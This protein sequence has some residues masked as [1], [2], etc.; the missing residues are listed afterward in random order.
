MA[1]H[2]MAEHD[3]A[4]H[5]MA[6]TKL[7]IAVQAERLHIHAT[8]PATCNCV[9]C[10]VVFVLLYFIHCTVHKINI[11]IAYK[12]AT[13]YFILV[14]QAKL[15]FLLHDATHNI[16]IHRWHALCAA[17]LCAQDV[18]SLLVSFCSPPACRRSFVVHL[19]AVGRWPAGLCRRVAS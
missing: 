16:A 10:Q 15:L 13:T 14:L 2:D 6:Q 11:I 7:C 18:R 5:S 4:L 3:M 12:N 8:K 9:N 19:F 1:E 17:W